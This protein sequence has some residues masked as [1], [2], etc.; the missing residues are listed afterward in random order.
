[1]SMW[2]C[3]WQCWIFWEKILPPKCWKWIKNCFF[4]NL[5]ENLVIYF[6]WIWSMKEVYIIW[7]ILVQ[8]LDLRK[9]WFLKFRPKCSQ[10]IRFQDFQIDY[11]SRAEWWKNL[12][13]INSWL[14]NIWL[15]M[16]R[17]EC[18]HS[19]LKTLKLAVSY[20]MLKV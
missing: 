8:I 20:Y 7:C 4:L 11:I 15:G 19:G 12:V 16:A 9:I 2:Y 5:F 1:M 10:P 3:A 17:S 14:K 6:F 13:E 18:G